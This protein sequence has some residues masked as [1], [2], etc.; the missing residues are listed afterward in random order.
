MFVLQLD[1][2]F[3]LSYVVYYWLTPSIDETTS[4]DINKP[5]RNEIRSG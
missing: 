1:N 4:K 3:I 5:F 2:I